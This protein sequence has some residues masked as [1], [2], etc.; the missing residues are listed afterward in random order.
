MTLDRTTL[1]L[2][3]DSA[4]TL[5][6]PQLL[7]TQ[8]CSHSH[9]SPVNSPCIAK[10]T[11]CTIFFS[12]QF[13]PSQWQMYGVC[14]DCG[15]VVSPPVRFR[16]SHQSGI[17]HAHRRMCVHVCKRVCARIC[18]PSLV[19]SELS[20]LK[21]SHENQSTG[22][23]LTTFACT[24]SSCCIQ[25]SIKTSNQTSAIVNWESWITHRNVSS[26]PTLGGDMTLS[27]RSVV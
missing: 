8:C 17:D 22:N 10:A 4:A 18:W 6:F 27:S 20:I 2:F 12:H 23:P 16:P 14:Y 7:R 13:L 24:A 5:S 21:A 19:Q 15:F 11:V 25:Q 9:D 26:S 3:S 1:G